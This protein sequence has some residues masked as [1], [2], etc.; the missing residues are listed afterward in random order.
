MDIL[1]SFLYKKVI[2][3]TIK[4]LDI[5]HCGITSCLKQLKYKK[6]LR[7]LRLPGAKDK[8]FPTRVS[9][10]LTPKYVILLV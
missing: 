9:I 3:S 8:L 2:F 10:F 7:I 4:L 6:M 5:I 1:S